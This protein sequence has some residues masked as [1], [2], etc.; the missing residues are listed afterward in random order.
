MNTFLKLNEN[1]TKKILLTLSLETPKKSLLQ[2]SAGVEN[3]LY[4]VE[5]AIITI[6]QDMELLL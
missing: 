6:V 2:M 4:F 5:A 1:K 3:F